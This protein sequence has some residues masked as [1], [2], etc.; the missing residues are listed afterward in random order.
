MTC[1]QKIEHAYLVEISQ[2][3][4]IEVSLEDLRL[5]QRAH[6]KAFSSIFGKEG[7]YL[8]SRIKQFFG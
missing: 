1:S 8:F 7:V 6:D 2:F 3:K 4:E 5:S